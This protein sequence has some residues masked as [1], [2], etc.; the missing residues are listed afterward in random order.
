MPGFRLAHLSDPHLGPLPPV[1]RRALLSKRAFGYVNWQRNRSR[2]LGSHALDALIADIA[3]ERPDHLAVTGDLVNIALPEEYAAATRWL[4][5]LGPPEA[6][7]VVP[8]NHDAYVPGGLERALAAWRAHMSDDQTGEA[9]VFPFVRLRPPVA[10]VGL[11]SAVPTPPLWAT[12]L[13]D[14]RQVEGLAQRLRLLGMERLFRV[15]LVHHPPLPGVTAFRK[16]LVGARRVLDVI[17]E[18]GAELVLH[19]HTHEASVAFV[20]GP[21]EAVPV[22][23]VPSASAGGAHAVPARYNIYE[24]GEARARHTCLMR[25]RGARGPG[26]PVVELQSRVLR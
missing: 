13:V 20:E 11:S 12:G 23:G 9:G 5:T 3:A 18:E 16:R 22:V 25:E 10:I 1:A 4:E 24:I 14:A 19:G 6:V 26:E 21:S 15:V 7:T 8:G 17:A 2:T